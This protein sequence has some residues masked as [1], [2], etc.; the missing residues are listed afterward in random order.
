MR[1]RALCGTVLLLLGLSV[2]E[3]QKTLGTLRG[4]VQAT[5]LRGQ[6]IVERGNL[7]ANDLG[8]LI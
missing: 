6:H 1:F 4:T 3:A 7:L 5:F 8:E 2:T